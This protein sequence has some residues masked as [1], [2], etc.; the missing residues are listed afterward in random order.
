MTE[1]YLLFRDICGYDD[2]SVVLG[3]YEDLQLAQSDREK[4]FNYIATNGD[5]HQC[6]PYFETDLNE[7]VQIV[8]LSTYRCFKISCE[9]P[10]SKQT[11][12]YIVRTFDSSVYALGC[13][14][15]GEVVSNID[16]IKTNTSSDDR[17]TCDAVIIN[18]LLQ[19]RLDRCDCFTCRRRKIVK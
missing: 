14:L 3:L 1:L 5:P 19:E 7:D 2:E 17:T 4:Y 9:L 8:N 16:D 10:V 6:T 12:L 15:Y 11:K 13:F 18:E